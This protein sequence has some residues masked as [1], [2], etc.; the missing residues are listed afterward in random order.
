MRE[1][2]QVDRRRAVRALL[3]A[4][5]I[6]LS[7]VAA[8]WSKDLP[9]NAWRR[10]AEGEG[11]L[12]SGA[13]LVG[14]EGRTRML[15]F[16]GELAGEGAYVRALDPA[17]G[18]WSDFA[19]AKPD[20]RRGIHPCGQTAYD[21]KGGKLH[22]LTYPGLLYTFDLLARKW[23]GPTEVPE[24]DGLS[25]HTM[26]VDPQARRLVVVAA[27]KKADN[28]GWTR[29]VICDLESGK[30][31]TLPPRPAPVVQRHRQIAAAGEALVELVGR[32]RLAWYRDPQGEGAA[33]QRKALADR[34]A[35]VAALPGLGLEAEAKEI[36]S[37]IGRAKLLEA[38][39]AARTLRRKVDELAHRQYP[40]PA[41]RRNSP[42][43]FD[44]ANRVFVLFGGDHEDYLTNDTW[45][46]DLA[47]QAWRRAA[48][49]LAPSPR[50]GHTLVYLPKC[51]RVGL[52]EGYEQ[53]NSPDYGSR[54]W[55]TIEPRQLWAYDARADRWDLLGGWASRKGE[56]SCPPAAGAFYGYSAQHFSAAALAADADDRLVLA[57]PQTRR[58]KGATWT[59]RLD[60][61]KPAAAREKLGRKPDQRL[62]RTAR[63]LAA[64]CEVPEPPKPTRLDALPANR[65]ARLPDVPRNVAYGC[66]QRDWGTAV[67]DSANE[68]VLLWGGGHCVRS[69]SSVIHY[70]PVS[71][72][73]V[74]SYDADEPYSANG[75]GGYD[76]SL[77]NRPWTGVHSYNTYAYDPPSGLMVSAR[78]YLYDPARM[79]W[80]RRERMKTP[81]RYVWSNTVLEATPHGVVA[82]A[83]MPEDSDRF[84]LWLFEKDRGWTDLKPQGK[85]YRPY[86]DSEGITYDAKRDRLILGW[87]GGYAK[88]GDGRLTTFDFKTR[89]LETIMPAGAELGRIMNTREMAYVDHAD[90]VAFAET[91]PRD[92][93]KPARPYLRVY[94]CARNRY[95][96]LDTGPGPEIKVY[97]QGWCYD[98]QRK[99]LF[100][101]TY[102]GAVY[103]LRFDPAGA[104]LLEAP[105]AGPKENP[106]DALGES[107]LRKG[108]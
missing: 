15:C 57:V 26:A 33:E 43:V 10:A 94:D 39:Q 24:L 80:L 31:R 14:V 60:V 3:P 42:L 5:W 67:W 100:V 41:S 97:G 58:E 50:A 56:A 37:L 30:W 104:K 76:S 36:A 82:W 8:C 63:F 86:C 105:P 51:G 95:F 6:A 74:E 65:W 99:L 35:A 81:F 12:G 89:R 96:L 91:Y 103:A 54:P 59:L 75:N 38:L 19:A 69:S 92:D 73:M 98:A 11:A 90:W 40:V 25:W 70:S 23:A 53:S 7:W 108:A 20:A 13:V 32:I 85:L 66:R 46:L 44:E 107:L 101:I 34:C 27:D 17:G 18:A 21:P 22:C 49:D 48:A 106:L 79:D 72:R 9:A 4:S 2:S 1:H 64:Y 61:S 52:Y 102:R 16:G 62:Y 68:Q 78:G 29:T 87:G 84:G 71:G 83:Q 55:R 77:L 93:P 28:L 47:A 45:V 88:A